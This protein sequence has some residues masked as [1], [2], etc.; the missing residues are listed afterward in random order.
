MAEQTSL[1]Y[2]EDNGEREYSPDLAEIIIEDP[3]D[4]RTSWTETP[5]Y[6]D[7]CLKRK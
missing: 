4:S 3:R 6:Y 1:Y 7:W 5:T 2:P